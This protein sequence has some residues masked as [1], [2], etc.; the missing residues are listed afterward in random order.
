MTKRT[1]MTHMLPALALALVTAAPAVAMTAGE[2]ARSACDSETGHPQ[3]EDGVSHAVAI[4]CLP[5][6]EVFVIGAPEPEAAPPDKDEP[7][8]VEIGVDC[9]MLTECE[10]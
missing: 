1:M 10:R 5:E 6:V 3:I 4:M 2:M 9:A 8:P 7:E